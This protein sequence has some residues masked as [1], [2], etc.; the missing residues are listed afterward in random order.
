MTHLEQYIWKTRFL[1]LIIAIIDKGSII[2]IDGAHTVHT[3]YKEHSG[4]VNTIGKGAMMSVSR[5]LCIVTNTS[6][7]TDVV[8]SGTHAQMH[9]VMLVLPYTRCISSGGYPN[10][11]Q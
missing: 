1:L 11:G 4:M 3:N 9:M 7:E 8:Y 5:K 10:A 2:Y 6:T